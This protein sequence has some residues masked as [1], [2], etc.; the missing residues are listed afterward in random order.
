MDV[1]WMQA[2]SGDA[3]VISSEPSH[4]LVYGF[5]FSATEQ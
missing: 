2:S 5:L 3:L 4:S 1:V